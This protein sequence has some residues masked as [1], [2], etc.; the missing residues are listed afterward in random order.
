MRAPCS[1][2]PGYAYDMCTERKAR[3]QVARLIVSSYIRYA[4]MW[5]WSHY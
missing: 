4:F 3:A 5:H 2:N 1:E